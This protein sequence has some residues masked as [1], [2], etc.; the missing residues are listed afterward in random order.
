VKGLGLIATPEFEE[1]RSRGRMSTGPAPQA[2]RDIDSE[3][4]A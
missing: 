1:H 4:P 3:V 2:D